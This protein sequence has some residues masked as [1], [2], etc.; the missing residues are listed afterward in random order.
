MKDLVV[1]SFKQNPNSE[2]AKKLLQYENFTHNTNELIDKAFLEGLKL[3]KKELLN[4]MQQ[5]KYEF[6]DNKKSSLSD[7]INKEIPTFKEYE[8]ILKDKKKEG[9]LSEKE[10]NELSLQ[11]KETLIW[12][13]KNCKLK[14]EKGLQANF[15]KGSKWEIVKDLKGYPSHSQGGVDIKLGKNGFSFTKDNSVIEA[16]HGLVLP[17]IK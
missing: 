17:K 7:A 13:A 14:A 9:E 3:A 1:E 6:N 12:Q 11:E 2:A 15:T 4:N 10:F 8:K 5:E 16:K